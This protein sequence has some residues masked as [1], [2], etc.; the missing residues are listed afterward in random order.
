[1]TTPP[2]TYT[3]AISPSFVAIYKAL[4]EILK[5]TEE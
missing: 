5:I 3:R 1:M 4:T 2:K